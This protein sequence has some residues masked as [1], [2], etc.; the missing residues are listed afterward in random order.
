MMAPHGKGIYARNPD[1]YPLSDPAG[2]ARSLRCAFVAMHGFAARDADFANARALG[3]KVFVWSGPDSWAPDRWEDT[4]RKLYGR[5]VSLRLDGLIANPEHGW[6]GKPSARRTLGATLQ[7][8]TESVAS[9][10]M[11]SYPAWGIEEIAETTTDVWVSP[12][13]YGVRDPGTPDELYQRAAKWRAY[14]GSVVPSLA[15]WSRGPFEQEAYLERFTDEQGAILWQAPSNEEIQPEPGSAT[16]EVLRD[17][18]PRRRRVKD[19]LS[20]AASHA[21][22]PFAPNRRT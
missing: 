3:L 10:G 14:F 21:A 7:S 5:V 15:A 6:Q 1:W 2:Y 8:V 22:F 4:L 9:V 20:V 18:Q 16:F 19:F 13:L 11:T 17:W 12:Q